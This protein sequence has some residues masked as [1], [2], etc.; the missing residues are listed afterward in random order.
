MASP[1]LLDLELLVAAIS[2]DRPTGSALRTADIGSANSA[3]QLFHRAKDLRSQARAAERNRIFEENSSET[4]YKFWYDISQLAQTLLAEHSKDVEVCTWLVEAQIRLNGITGLRDSLH[5]L[6]QLIDLYWGELFPLPDEDGIE[7][8]LISIH[9]LNGD[10]KNGTLLAPL[11]TV[12]LAPD[13]SKGSF[14]FWQLGQARDVDRLQDP[15]EKA[16]REKQ[17]GI[18]WE[19]IQQIVS[20]TPN[21]YYLNL[22]DDLQLSITALQQLDSMLTKRCADL[23]PSF[24]AVRNLLSGILEAIRNVAKTKLI[25]AVQTEVEVFPSESAPH[26]GVLVC[27][28]GAPKSRLQALAQLKEIALFFRQ[29]EPHSPISYA[30]EKAIR[31]GELPLHEL[32]SEL[33]PDQGAR[34]TFSLMTGVKLE[35]ESIE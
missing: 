2:E 12:P 23:A 32:I 20:L 30:V 3:Y 14:C 28:D 13:T 1:Q 8:T 29:T 35:L 22:V 9:G 11:N 10:G 27:Q 25:S 6:Q 26:A 15:D 18:K 21:A 7:T 31:W 24:S 4:G 34:S 16:N 5:A 19:D 33:I 17:L